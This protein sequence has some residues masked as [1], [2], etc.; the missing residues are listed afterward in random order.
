MII[1]VFFN[2]GHS[3]ILWY[4]DG[5]FTCLKLGRFRSVPPIFQRD[6][7]GQQMQQGDFIPI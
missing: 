7:V 2:P 6:K 3:M 4:M 5:S 1:V